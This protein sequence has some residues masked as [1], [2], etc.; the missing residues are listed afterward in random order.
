MLAIRRQF[1]LF[2]LS[3]LL[4]G[5]VFWA[6]G[7]LVTQQL[8]SLSYRTPDKLQADTLPQVL[9]TLNFKVINL[10]IKP[11]DKS[12]K[13]IIKTSNSLL[14]SLELEIPNSQDTEIAIAQQLGLSSQVKK[15]AVNQR[16]NM[17]FRLNLIAI[18]AAVI[19]EQGFSY[20]DV[21]TAN[22]S[23][24]K[25]HFVLPTADVKSLEVKIAQL[26]NLSREDVRKLIS[27]QVKTQ[28]LL[29]PQP[30]QRTQTEKDATT[31]KISMN[32]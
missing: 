29:T 32:N 10:Q 6:G 22:N 30:K 28:S 25:L 12:T 14:K 17:E 11:E 26:L 4:I 31:E 15:I 27:Y 2:L 16:L 3:F 20:V 5:F 13:V 9:L 19:Q 23:V 8:L 24:T 18:K 21:I 7:D 1:F